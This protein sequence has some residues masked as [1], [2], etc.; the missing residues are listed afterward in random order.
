MAIYIRINGIIRLR[1]GQEN[2]REYLQKRY[3]Q[4]YPKKG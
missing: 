2:E 1:D 4:E 3:E